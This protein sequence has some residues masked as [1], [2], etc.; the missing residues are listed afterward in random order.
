MPAPVLDQLQTAEPNDWLVAP[1]WQA[2]VSRF[3][4]SDVGCQLMAFLQQRLQDGTR[5]YPPQPL[6]ALE[7][8]APEAVRVVILGQDR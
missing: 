1:G 6:R 7:L 3:F 5:I 2:L 4:T 8:T